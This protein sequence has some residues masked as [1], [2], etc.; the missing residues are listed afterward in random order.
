MGKKFKSRRSEH[1]MDAS[2]QENAKEH[3]PA[4][5]TRPIPLEAITADA[6]AQPR[7]QTD[8]ELVTE[9]AARMTQTSMRMVVDPEGLEFEPIVVFQHGE[10]YWLADGFHRISAAKKAGCSHFQAKVFQGTQRDAIKHSLSANA[11]H[12]SR[13]TRADKRRA[14]TR[15][16]QDDTWGRLSDRQ[17]ATLCAVAQS[18]VT[19]IKNTLTAAGELDAKQSVKGA[20]GKTYTARKSN[21]RVSR[22][23]ASPWRSH[24]TT[25]RATPSSLEEHG[26]QADIILFDEHLDLDHLEQATHHLPTHGIIALALPTSP[27]LA[28]FDAL[29][30]LGRQDRLGE[31]RRYSEGNYIVVAFPHRDRETKLPEQHKISFSKLLEH[32][33]QSLIV[34]TADT[35]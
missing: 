7:E 4:S 25:R 27:T 10:T 5:T 34:L 8:S 17:I 18:T 26:G 11:R 3:S 24:K 2:L 33:G 28:H 6:S 19:R 32:V 13:R 15:A 23:K 29:S 9:Y 12:G 31:P 14:V 16:L 1:K 35:R 22:D 20:D 21:T 30:S